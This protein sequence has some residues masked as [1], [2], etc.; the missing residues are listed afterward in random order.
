M[1][2][3]MAPRCGQRDVTRAGR[4]THCPAHDPVKGPVTATSWR[5]C[6]HPGCMSAAAVSAFGGIPLCRGHA[7][8]VRG[9]TRETEHARKPGNPVTSGFRVSSDQSPPVG[10]P[11]NAETRKCEGCGTELSGFRSQARFCSDRCRKRATNG[12]GG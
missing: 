3:C 10:N 11:G 5:R 8:I 4:L 9:G 2:I 12:R 1:S 6:F 7:A